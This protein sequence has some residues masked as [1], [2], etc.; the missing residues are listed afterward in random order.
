MWLGSPP[1][2]C[3]SIWVTHLGKQRWQKVVKI[4]RTSASSQPALL[5]LPESSWKFKV[6]WKVS[7]DQIFW[8]FK[9]SFILWTVYWK[10]TNYDYHQRYRLFFP[11]LY[12]RPVCPSMLCA[13]NAS[14]SGAAI[15]SLLAK[16]ETSV[17]F[18]NTTC[19]CRQ[20]LQIML[21]WQICAAAPFVE[22]QQQQTRSGDLRKAWSESPRLRSAGALR[23]ICSLQCSSGTA[24]TILRWNIHKKSR[25][26]AQSIRED[27]GS[28]AVSIT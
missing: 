9:Q 26:S 7:I 22:Q 21:C 15:V 16:F 28:A 6:F 11:I 14:K 3:S 12:L 25:T 5:H 18:S 4:Q 24:T 20:S 2:S 23:T 8:W 10:K 17:F 19:C 27:W 1:A 13:A